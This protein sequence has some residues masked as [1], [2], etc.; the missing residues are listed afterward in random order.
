MLTA[1]R[2]KISGLVLFLDRPPGISDPLAP[3]SGAQPAAAESRVL[4]R[5]DIVRGGHPLSRNRT[6][7][8]Q[9]ATCCH[10]QRTPTGPAGA[11]R[12][13]CESARLQ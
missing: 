3:R 10:C 11:P 1:R 8:D 6:R 7:Y 5:E 9:Q 4:Q 12:R 13:P 2:L